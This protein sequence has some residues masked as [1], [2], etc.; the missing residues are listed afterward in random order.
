MRRSDS[1]FARLIRPIVGSPLRSS[2]SLNERPF[3]LKQTLWK[4][5]LSERLRSAE[6]IFELHLDRLP[7]QSVWHWRPEKPIT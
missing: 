5:T 4:G 1:L 2:I 3:P 6:G 7:K